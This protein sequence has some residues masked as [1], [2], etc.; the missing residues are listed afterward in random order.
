MD[1]VKQASSS[2]GAKA[3]PAGFALG[4]VRWLRTCWH[5]LVAV[6]LAVFFVAALLRAHGFQVLGDNAFLGGIDAFGPDEE[7]ELIVGTVIIAGFTVTLLMGAVIRA[8]SISIKGSNVAMIAGTF[9]ALAM[10][11]MVTP[12]I[13]A[14]LVVVGAVIDLGRQGDTQGDVYVGFREEHWEVLP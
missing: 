13:L 12:V 7:V 5:A 6:Q 11:W 2:H 1:R 10:I 8:A 9:P 4:A 14:A 3:A